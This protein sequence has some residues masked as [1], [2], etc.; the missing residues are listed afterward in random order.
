V[1]IYVQPVEDEDEAG[2]REQI[3]GAEIGYQTL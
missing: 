1:R 2:N 3:R